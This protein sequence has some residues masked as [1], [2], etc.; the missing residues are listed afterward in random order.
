MSGGGQT[1][2]AG[3]YSAWEA[4]GDKGPIM[5]DMSYRAPPA[6]LTSGPQSP[7][8][9][10]LAAADG[11]E[12]DMSREPGLLGSTP[13]LPPPYALHPSPPLVPQFPLPGSVRLGLPLP[14]VHTAPGLQG[15]LVLVSGGTHKAE[16]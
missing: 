1:G 5:E 15:S 11:R 8:P 16:G 7:G 14:Q 10:A 4:L 2:L 12:R 13:A 3:S 6:P 9:P